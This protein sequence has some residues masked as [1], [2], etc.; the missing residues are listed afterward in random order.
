MNKYTLY[1]GTAFVTVA[2]LSLLRR[3]GSVVVDRGPPKGFETLDRLA[4]QVDAYIPGFSQFAR[5]AAYGESGGK[6]TA[7]ND[8]PSEAAAACRGYQR[9]QDSVYANNPYPAADW[10]WGS[11]GWFGFLPSTG[12][13]APG[14]RN[15]NPRLVFDPA[16][17][18][19]MF[20]DFVRRVATGQL[21]KLP[22][23]ERNWLAVRR[24]MAGNTVGLDWQEQK[25]LN[26]DTDGIPRAR[27]V[28]ER[29]AKHLA[30]VG[31][32]ESVMYQPVTISSAY[33]GA[34]ALWKMLR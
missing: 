3:R 24:F 29:L 11:G 32:S 2:L 31:L 18:V 15:E 9:L 13:Y 10:C 19:A 28:R 30:A 22:P 5:G 17:S 8:S 21:H 23:D 34:A 25:V 14:F 4:Q 7:I 20:A 27:K 26:S 12:L 33:P 1:A 6:S 16:A